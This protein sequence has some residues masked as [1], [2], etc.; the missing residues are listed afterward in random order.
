MRVPP[1]TGRGSSCQRRSGSPR[2][3][4]TTGRQHH[5]VVAEAVGQ[6]AEDRRQDELGEVERRARGQ[7]ERSIGSTSG[8]PCSGQL[9]EVD[10]S[11]APVSPVLKRS[12]KVPP[13]RPRANDP[14]RRSVPAAALDAARDACP[15]SCRGSTAGP[16]RRRSPWPASRSSPTPRPTSTRRVAAGRGH[17]RRPAASSTSATET[18]R[19]GVDLST[20]RVLGADDRARTRRSRRPRPRARATSRTS[21]RPPSPRAPTRSSR[22]HVAGTLSGAIKSAEIARD[23][24][25]DREIHVV[26]SL[27]ASMAEAILVLDRPGARGRG[28]RPR[29][30]S[31]RRSRPRAPTCGCTSSLETLEYLK[32]GGRISGAQ[33][34]IG[35]LLSVKPIIAVKDGVVETADKP[36]TRSKARERCIE[37]ITERPIERTRDPPHDGARRRRRSATRSSAAPAASTR[38]TCRSMLVGAVGRAAPRSGLRRR[39]G[40]VPAL[41]AADRR[42]RHRSSRSAR[43]RW[44]QVRWRQRCATV[45]GGPSAAVRR[46]YTPP[47]AMRRAIAHDASGAPWGRPGDDPH[48]SGGRPDRRT[49][50]SVHP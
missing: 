2:P 9:G 29:P 15:V 27:G 30:R 4:R 38:P 8:P 6:D 25:P 45:D 43:G 13:A 42:G 18:F 17:P 49:R 23:M 1:R 50:R 35:T 40:P 37:L 19:A 28:R 11:I 36:R 22:V 47:S 24:L 5:P 32:K 3:P 21:T 7:A 12:V 26:D 16:P 14:S 34:A 33:A 46:G 44:L 31:P 48:P 39:G 41:T 20:A 10:A